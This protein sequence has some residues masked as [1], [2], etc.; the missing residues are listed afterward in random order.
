[1]RQQVPH[2]PA[3]KADIAKILRTSD[4][5]LI[6]H[7]MATGASYTELVEALLRVTQEYQTDTD[8]CLP[9]HRVTRAMIFLAIA[10]EA[11]QDRS[12]E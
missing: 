8:E 6:G 2:N 12:D 7:T 10:R 1:M 9:S 3:T 11:T 4:A 5:E